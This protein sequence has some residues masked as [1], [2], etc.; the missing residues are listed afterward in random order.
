MQLIPGASFVFKAKKTSIQQPMII[1]N[2][3]TMISNYVQTQ[4]YIL[5]ILV[6]FLFS[7]SI[8]YSESAKNKTVAYRLRWTNNQGEH[9][10]WSEIIK[11][12]II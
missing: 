8:N 4:K 11:S 3:T 6:L 12:K 2:L 9:G 5:R 10:P 1:E 7:I